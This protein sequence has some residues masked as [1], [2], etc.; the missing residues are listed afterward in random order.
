MSVIDIDREQLKKAIKESPENLEIIDVR[1][2]R[3]FETIHLKNSRL[4]PMDQLM[5]RLGEIDWSKRVI[6]ICRSGSRSK[7]MAN[8]VSANTKHEV[9]N[10]KYGIF[11]CWQD[12]EK[13]HGNIVVDEKSIGSYF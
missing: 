10:L 6:F 8:L 9:A 3:E 1:T 13:C 2:E 7:L 5:S 11:E 12:P 4:M